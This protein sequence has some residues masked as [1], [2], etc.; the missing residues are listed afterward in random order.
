MNNAK[1]QRKT[2]TW[3]RI[4]NS[5]RKLEILHLKTGTI[6]DT[7]SKDLAEAEEIKKKGQEYKNYTKKVL[8][9][10]IKMAMCLL[11]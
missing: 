6:K 11:T 9:T 2:I 7:N 3:E 5:L 10:Q 4:E 8:M 1:K